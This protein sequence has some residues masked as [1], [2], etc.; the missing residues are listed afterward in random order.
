M[1]VTVIFNEI[2]L[3]LKKLN[4]AICRREGF[5]MVDKSK[6]SCQ[7]PITLVTFVAECLLRILLFLCLLLNREAA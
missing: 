7:C 3:A 6:F 5:E 1:Q 2:Q 4:N